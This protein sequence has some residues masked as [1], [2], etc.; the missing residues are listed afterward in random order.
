MRAIM[1]AWVHP[2]DCTC[3]MNYACVIHALF[4]NRMCHMS[5]L[6]GVGRVCVSAF[7]VACTHAF[8]CVADVYVAHV[9]VCLYAY[10]RICL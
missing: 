5:W 9:Y 7:V 4:G 1:Y 10:V 3:C 6:P 2:M 8:M